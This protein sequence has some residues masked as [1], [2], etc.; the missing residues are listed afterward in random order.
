MHVPQVEAAYLSVHNVRH[1]QER[2]D[3]RPG[4]QVVAGS[5]PVSPT[6]ACR[7]TRQRDSVRG[8]VQNGPLK[9]GRSRSLVSAES[10]ALPLLP[11]SRYVRHALSRF[12]L[13]CR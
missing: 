10:W 8:V 6:K 12:A 5:N 9:L 1:V 3:N 7:S 4:G 11:R 2:G 13:M